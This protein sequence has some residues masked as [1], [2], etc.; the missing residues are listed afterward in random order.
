MGTETRAQGTGHR[1]Q[2]TGHRD[3]DTGHRDQD[4][5]HKYQHTGTQTGHRHT[6][7][8]SYTTIEALVRD[9]HTVRERDE[10]T[11]THGHKDQHTDTPNSTWAHRTAHGHRPTH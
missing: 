10:H 1:D 5:G 6:D 11:G 8:H 7:Q 3:Q 2:D 4:T 9:Q